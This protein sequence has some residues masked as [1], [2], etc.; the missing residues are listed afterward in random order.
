MVGWGSPSPSVP[1]MMARRGSAH[2]F[3]SSM[4]TDLSVRAIATVLKPN[5]FN[6]EALS[7]QVHG[8]RNTVPIDD[9]HSPAVQ[10]SQDVGVTSTASIPRAAAE[11]KMAPI[12]VVST[13]PSITA[14]RLALQHTSST[15]GGA[16]RR[17]AQSTPRVSV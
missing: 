12:L 3:L 4:D 8:T 15:L 17:I 11:R 1:I 10:G 7:I 6:S 14:T 9:S 5:F 13:T 16:G 2:N